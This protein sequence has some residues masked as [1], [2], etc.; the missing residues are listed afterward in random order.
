LRSFL[1]ALKEGR[2]VELADSDKEKCLRTLAHLIEAIPELGGH[3]NL[4]EDILAREREGNTAIGLGVACPHMRSAGP[5]ELWCAVGWSPAGIDYGARD[6]QKVYLVVMYYIPDS[7]K[8]TYLKEVSALAAAVKKEGGIQ[9]ISG[10]KD[11]AT[12]RDRLLDWVASAIDA[13]VPESHAR[14][15][16]LEAR[17][18]VAPGAAEAAL[19]IYPVL[20]LSSDSALT[21]LCPNQQ[22]SAALEKDNTLPPLLKQQISFDRLGF[23]FVY[24]SVTLYDPTR[25]LY[26]YVAVKL[27][28]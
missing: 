5:G 18:A 1:N 16:R 2:L 23:R 6:G 7:Q 26:D 28:S 11:I 22:L 8:G 24:R 17:Q 27:A 14:M 21:V 25:P 3:L 19:Q 12:V 20:I 13:G 4:D 9:T 15:V 10:A